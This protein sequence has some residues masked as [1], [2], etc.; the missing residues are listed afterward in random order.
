M[1]TLFM[2]CGLPGSGNT[3]LA[4][5]IESEQRALRLSPDEWMARIVG[6]GYDEARRAAVESV[7]WEIAG[8]LLALGI[9]VI[10]ENGF[11]SRSERDGFKARAR[12]LG[13][14]TKL[15]FLD[16]DRNELLRRLA[17][18]NVALPRDTF[19][20]DEA[21]LNS[22]INSFERPTPDELE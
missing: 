15:Y 5:Q 2:I 9:D 18:R 8:R 12:A 22:C 10:L 11:W 19:H 17:L 21:L 14:E 4:R 20:V 13:A 1:P 7:Q 3:T 6:E 16:V